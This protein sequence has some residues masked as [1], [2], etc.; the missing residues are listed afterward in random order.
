MRPVDGAAFCIPFV[1]AAKFD[2]LAGFQLI[3]PRGKVDIVS[4]EQGLAIG[5]TKNESLM[6]RTLKIVGQ[7]LDNGS[8]RFDRD[9]RFLIMEGPGDYVILGI[10]RDMIIITGLSRRTVIGAIT[11][12]NKH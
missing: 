10:R 9:I 8:G 6:H 11:T 5:E 4:D 1:F 3:K 2:F 12:T 7:D